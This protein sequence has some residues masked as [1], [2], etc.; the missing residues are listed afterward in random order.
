MKLCIV[1]FEN[2]N[3]W[4]CSAIHPPLNDGYQCTNILKVVWDTLQYLQG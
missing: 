4:T 3:A 2:K 1:S